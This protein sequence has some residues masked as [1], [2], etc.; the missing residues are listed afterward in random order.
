MS[1]R[2]VTEGG[3]ELRAFL[4]EQGISVP[5][6]CARHGIDRIQVQRVLNGERYKRI[7]VEFAHAIERAT[8]G[9][10]AYTKF[11]PTTAEPAAASDSGEHHTVEP[12]KPTGTEG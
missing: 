11:L 9:R 10:I 5:G 1:E 7:S 2:K 3:R 6:F 8:S 12:A 4:T